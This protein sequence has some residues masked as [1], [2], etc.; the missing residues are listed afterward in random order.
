MP[1]RNTILRRQVKKQNI[2]QVWASSET[3]L[4]KIR[5]I[6][7]E[8]K[9][10]TLQTKNEVLIAE[11]DVTSYI[12]FMDGYQHQV[13]IEYTQQEELSIKLL[14]LA[15]NPNQRNQV[16]PIAIIPLK[17][18]DYISLDNGTAYLGFCQETVNLANQLL[19]ENW[20]FESSVKA[21]QK[22][23][24]GGLSLVYDCNWPIHL[25]F[26]PDIN[27]KYNTLY[28]FLL[29]IKRVQLEL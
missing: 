29:P 6:V 10:E 28:R 19:I 27:E 1:T 14:D 24:W 21:N 18:T 4:G 15:P 26:S 11:L 8:Q 16:E 5:N 12:D 13:L 22:D 17:L 3:K 23:P 2:I 9:G 25:M 20:V 7:E